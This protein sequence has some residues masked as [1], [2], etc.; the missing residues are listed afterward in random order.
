MRT[1]YPSEWIATLER[2][3]AID[4]TTIVPGH[5]FVEDPPTMRAEFVAFRHAMGSVVAEAIRLHG[6]G[7]SVPDAA[8]GTLGRYG[9]WTGRDRNAP[10]A[11]HVSMTSSTAS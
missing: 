4:A 3:A 1:A 5:G 8:A 2:V 6:L 9:T 11:I 10:I 7:L